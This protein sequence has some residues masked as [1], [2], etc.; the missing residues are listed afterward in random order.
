MYRR[1]GIPTSPR[2]CSQNY[3]NCVKTKKGGK[4]QLENETERKKKRKLQIANCK[5]RLVA[6]IPHRVNENY[7]AI[8]CL[9]KLKYF[10]KNEKKKKK[11]KT[12]PTRAKKFTAR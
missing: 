11:M 8:L 7:A 2:G 5:P 9:K 4:V 12:V 6:Y 3:G 1:I 10:S